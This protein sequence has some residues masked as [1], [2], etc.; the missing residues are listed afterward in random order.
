MMQ[1]WLN[2]AA[3]AVI[4]AVSTGCATARGVAAPAQSDPR[5]VLEER[6]L[7]AVVRLDAFEAVRRLKPH[8][9][10]G[11]G[12]V[13]LLDPGREA[14]RVYLDGMLNGDAGSLRRVPMQTVGQIEFLDSRKATLRFGTGHAEGAIL[15]TTR[16]GSR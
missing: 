6:D 3:L 13:A 7:V 4:V 16:H 12:Q 2:R 1:S 10:S 8:W 11:R 9:L 15:V 5:N 14:V